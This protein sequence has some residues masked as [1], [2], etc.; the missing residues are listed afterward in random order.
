MIIVI[1]ISIEVHRKWR[2]VTQCAA[3][4]VALVPALSVVVPSLSLPLVWLDNTGL[5]TRAALG[6][7]SHQRS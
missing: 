5:S 3:P 4:D 6:L 2:P 7:A 1:I